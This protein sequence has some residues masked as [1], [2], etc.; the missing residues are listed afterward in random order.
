[1]HHLWGTRPRASIRFRSQNSGSGLWITFGR[2]RKSRVLIWVRWVHLIDLFSGFGI[3]LRCDLVG[4]DLE[5]LLPRP[6]LIFAPARARHLAA[7]RR[8]GG[9]F[10]SRDILSSE[11]RVKYPSWPSIEAL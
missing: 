4:Y 1:M 11:S 2:H 6:P 7:R 3:G 8:R 5:T 10:R 9:A